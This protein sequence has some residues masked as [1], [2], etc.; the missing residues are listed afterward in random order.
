MSKHDQRDHSWW[1][2]QHGRIGYLVLYALG[3]PVGI[4]L[5]LW[6]VFGDNLLGPG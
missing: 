3:V 4:L 1:A 6:A 2:T 5:L